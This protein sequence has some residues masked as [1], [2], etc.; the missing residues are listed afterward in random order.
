MAS[1][2]DL[3]GKI[4]DIFESNIGLGTTFKIDLKGEGFIHIGD[5]GVCNEDLP[6]DLTVRVSRADLE[7][8]GRGRLNPM[9]AVITGRL[10]VSDMSL[11]MSLQPQMQ[12][13]FAKLA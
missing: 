12:A 5:T 13:L 10:Q 8:L 1:L 9:T 2:E 7:A 4:A 3:T 11:A 6:A